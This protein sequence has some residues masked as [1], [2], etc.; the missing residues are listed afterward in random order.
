MVLCEEDRPVTRR[1]LA[2]ELIRFYNE[3]VEPGIDRRIEERLAAKLDPFRQ[4]VLQLFD[5][6]FKKLEDFHQEYLLINLHI[7][8]LDDAVFPKGSPK[9]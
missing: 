8:R 3:V 4:E 6:V 2:V 9:N 5:H 1:E 7:R